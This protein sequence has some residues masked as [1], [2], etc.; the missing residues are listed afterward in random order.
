MTQKSMRYDHPA[1]QARF[2]HGFGQNAAGA[3]TAFGKYVAFTQ[4]KV[5]AIQATLATV[6]TSTYTAWNGTNTTTNVAGDSFSLIH[7]F[8]NGGTAATSTATHGPFALG[9]YN[10]TSTAVQTA[11]AGATVRVQLYGTA[12]TGNVQSGSNT[13]DGGVT[14]YPGDTLHILRGTDATAVSAFAIELGLDA[15]NGGANVTAPA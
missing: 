2:A 6:G 9:L 4:M 3:S 1:Y 15:S 14:V 13:A 12:V 5:Y 7:V 11:T 10:G 8:A